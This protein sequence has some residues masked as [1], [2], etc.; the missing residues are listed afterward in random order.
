MKKRT[1][2]SVRDAAADEGHTWPGGS[3][4]PQTAGRGRKKRLG[5]SFFGFT[6]VCTWRGVANAE[7]FQAERS[8]KLR[9]KPCPHVPRS[10]SAPLAGHVTSIAGA[11]QTVLDLTSIYF[12]VSLTGSLENEKRLVIYL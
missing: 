1:H 2:L 4:A 7:N 8:D 9:S 6:C 12:P 3:S 10:H 11:P 5:P